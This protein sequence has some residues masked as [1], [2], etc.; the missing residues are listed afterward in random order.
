MVRPRKMIHV[1]NLQELQHSEQVLRKEK[2]KRI[3]FS[4]NQQQLQ[5]QAVQ[6]QVVPQV[7]PAL[8]PIPRTVK[9]MSHRLWSYDPLKHNR[10][11]PKFQVQKLFQSSQFSRMI[12]IPNWERKNQNVIFWHHFKIWLLKSLNYSQEQK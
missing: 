1:K 3:H 2:L 5:Q 6:A 8:L 10:R 7:Q 4:K 9:M 12:S 11:V